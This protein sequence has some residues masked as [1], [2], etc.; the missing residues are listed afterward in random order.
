[1][2]FRKNVLSKE[3][4]IEQAIVQHYSELSPNAR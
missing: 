4:S 3:Q 2:G 1:M